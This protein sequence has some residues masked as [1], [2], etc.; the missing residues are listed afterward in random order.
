MIRVGG[1]LIG[2]NRRRKIMR[3]AV[4]PYW[5][6]EALRLVGDIIVTVPEIPDCRPFH[7]WIRR[8]KTR[9]PVDVDKRVGWF[10]HGVVGPT[11]FRDKHGGAGYAIGVGNA[12]Q[13]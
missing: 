11:P 3:Q 10:R 8:I 13:L 6:D 4:F 12:K 1:C 7:L 5:F 2:V 9:S